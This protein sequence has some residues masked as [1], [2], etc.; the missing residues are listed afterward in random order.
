[1]VRKRTRKGAL[2]R[3]RSK[4]VSLG[5]SRG[6]SPYAFGNAFGVVSVIALLFYSVMV[7]FASFDVTVIISK[8]PLGFSFDDWTILIGL[9]QT[10]AMS[11]VGGWI[12]ARI[13]N[14]TAG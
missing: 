14:K 12:F 8:Y 11:Y 5:R 7:W 3:T 4:T 9:A 13:Y 10:Y 6:L 1:M 2:S